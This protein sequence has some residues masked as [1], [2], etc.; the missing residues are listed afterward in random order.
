[1][2]YHLIMAKVDVAIVGAGLNGLIAALALAG[3][4]C[5]QPLQVALIDKTDPQIF[6]SNSLDSRA[7]A[8]TQATQCMFD[9]LGL[10]PHVKTHAQAMTNI[11]VTDGKQGDTRPS[12]LSF[13]TEAGEKPAAAM[14]ENIHL[15]AAALKCVE[16]APH[17]QC[18]Y[19]QA[20][21]AINFGPG[22]AR[23][24]FANGAEIKAN[25][26]IGADGRNSLC[27]EAAQIDFKGWNYGQSAITLT[28]Q[29]EIAHNGV[30]EEHFTPHGVFAILPL[31]HH[32]SSLVWT[33]E[34]NEAQRLAG[35]PDAEFLA[36]L[37]LR[38]GAQR[39]AVSIIGARHVHPL[40]LK[41]ATNMTGERLALIGDAAHVV[42]PLAGLGLNLGFKDAAALAECVA[43]CFAFG[44]DVGGAAALERY[45]TWRRFDTVSTAYLIDGLNSLF[46]NDIM[47]LKRVRDL[48]CNWWTAAPS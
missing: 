3:P 42:H 43:D 47:A 39:G 29:H 26:I 16:Q 20:P 37:G 19:G 10:W 21:Q 36:E 15:F 48:G 22:L 46:A 28:V 6:T 4:Q 24:S 12:L 35:L 38:F 5:R 27:R 17:I 1:M 9:V 30:A 13:I 11:I 18:F 40:S 45:E 44:G 41:L 7:S 32:R 23:V 25:L 34:H 14:V 8:I 2:G 33:E 31:T